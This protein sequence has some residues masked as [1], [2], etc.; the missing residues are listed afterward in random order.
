MTQ[1]L[2]TIQVG[3]RTN[4][5]FL[6]YWNIALQYESK[7]TLFLHREGSY[8]PRLISIDSRESVGDFWKKLEPAIPELEEAEEAWEGDVKLHEQEF[9]A[10]WA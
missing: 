5:L 7:E 2:I 10:G 6:H 1:E 9:M 4:N 3:S 8:R